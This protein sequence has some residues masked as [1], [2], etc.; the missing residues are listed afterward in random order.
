M[1]ESYI[2]DVKMNALIIRTNK[3]WNQLLRERELAV[4]KFSYG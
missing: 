1:Q 2:V 3:H 4:S